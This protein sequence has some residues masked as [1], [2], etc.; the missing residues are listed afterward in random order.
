MRGAPGGNAR[1]A[2]LTPTRRREISSLAAHSRWSKQPSLK[3]PT[4]IASGLLGGL[5]LPVVCAVVDAGEF[6]QRVVSLTSLIERLHL[7]CSVKLNEAGIPVVEVCLGKEGRVHAMVFG[8]DH[9]GV[10][11]EGVGAAMFIKI[12]ASYSGQ[13]SIYGYLIAQKVKEWSENG[14]EAGVNAWINLSCQFNVAMFLEQLHS[15]QFPATMSAFA[16]V[17]LRLPRQFVVDYCR[18][19]RLMVR[20]QTTEERITELCAF[21]EK[22]VL[23]PLSVEDREQALRRKLPSK[24]GQTEFGVKTLSIRVAVVAAVLALSDNLDQLQFNLDKI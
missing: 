5:D 9:E 4:K 16:T 23:A 18:V 13:D 8:F 24:K 22:S 1:A 19:S 21:V 2:A 3:R 15:E 7:N 10:H 14:G 17:V 20:F 11:H 6:K 12:L